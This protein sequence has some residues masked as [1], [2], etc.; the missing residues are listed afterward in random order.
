M[1]FSSMSLDVTACHSKCHSNILSRTRVYIAIYCYIAL[2]LNIAIMHL[3]L[4]LKMFFPF[5]VYC[6]FMSK[7][8]SLKAKSPA[9]KFRELVLQGYPEWPTW[10][11][12]LRR[13]FVSLPS[14]GVGKDSLE[15]MC[16]DFDWDLDATSRLIARTKTFQNAIAEFVNNDYQYRTVS[17]KTTGGN[18]KLKFEI[19]WSLLQQVYMLESGITSF[20]KAETG[21]VS[22]AET[23]L[24]EKAGLLE[25][26][27]VVNI[28]ANISNTSANTVDISGEH[29]LYNLEA[30]LNGA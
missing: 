18:L 7:K 16:E 15:S 27:P 24:I 8:N 4:F 20:I 10:S 14:Y 3:T 28:P 2:L 19:R 29:S 30:S 23:K 12:K 21:K 13:I 26:E 25:I 5:L 17:K 6:F 9:E 22:A 1:F 11:R